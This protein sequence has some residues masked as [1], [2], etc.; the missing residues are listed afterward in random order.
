[1]H[2]FLDSVLKP[3]ATGEQWGHI[4]KASGVMELLQSIQNCMIQHQTCQKHIHS[5][6]DAEAQV[7][8]FKQKNL[9]N[10]KYYE[11]FKDLVTNAN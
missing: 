4:N 10:N 9:P 8:G 2:L 1:M 3:S 7:Y 5:L 6:L 11:K